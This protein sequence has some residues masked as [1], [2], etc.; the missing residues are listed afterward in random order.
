MLIYL[1]NEVIFWREGVHTPLIIPKPVAGDD[2]MHD[3]PLTFLI[4]HV[5]HDTISQVELLLCPYPL[6]H[7]GRPGVQ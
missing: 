5:M 4:L 1:K 6:A 3:T 7:T 2:C